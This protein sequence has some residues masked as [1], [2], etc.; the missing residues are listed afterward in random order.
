[1]TSYLIKLTYPTSGFP[2]YTR[3]EVPD[4]VV[5]RIAEPLIGIRFLK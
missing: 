5:V 1:V 3:K 4:I 2:D